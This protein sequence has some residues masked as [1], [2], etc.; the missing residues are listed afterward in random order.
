[1]SAPRARAAWSGQ[2]RI[3]QEL[4]GEKDRIG[5]AGGDDLLRLCG[6]GDQ[7][8]RTRGDPDLL[9]DGRGKGDLVTRSRRDFGIRNQSS[10]GAFSCYP[11]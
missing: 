7:A 9:A 2:L 11:S 4:T 10:T 6:F 1:M 8:H 5:L 3:A